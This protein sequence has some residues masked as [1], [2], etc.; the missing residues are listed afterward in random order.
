MNWVVYAEQFTFLGGGHLLFDGAGCFDQ[1]GRI[2]DIQRNDAQPCGRLGLEPDGAL[3]GRMVASGVD[4]EAQAV[5]VA[6]QVPSERGVA[7]SDQHSSS[8]HIQQGSAAQ[9]TQQIKDEGGDD[10]GQHQHLHSTNSNQ[11]RIHFPPGF[12]SISSAL[13]Q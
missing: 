5:V 7:S 12:S 9:V 11:F 10:Q 3:S 4:A 8:G 6:G 2:G 1:R 13:I